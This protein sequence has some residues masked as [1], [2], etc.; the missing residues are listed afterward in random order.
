MKNP[1][2][3]LIVLISI[4]SCSS[5]KEK[6]AHIF[7]S[8]DSTWQVGTGYCSSY[9]ARCR[10]V[11]GKIEGNVTLVSH[12]SNKIYSEETYMGG[13]KTGKY[14]RYLEPGVVL[15]ETQLLENEGKFKISS[16]TKGELSYILLFEKEIFY[17]QSY[18]DYE[19]ILRSG[20][21]IRRFNYDKSNVL[22]QEEIYTP[23]SSYRDGVRIYYN[24]DGSISGKIDLKDR[25][26]N[27]EG[28]W[29]AK[30]GNGS[31][32]ERRTYL[33]GILNGTCIT[34][35]PN[36]KIKLECNYEDG[37]LKGIYREYYETG[38]PKKVCNY[39]IINYKLYKNSEIRGLNIVYFQNGDSVYEKDDLAKRWEEAQKEQREQEIEEQSYSSD[40]Q[41][42]PECFGHYSAGFCTQCG[43]ASS[44]R[45]NQSYSKLAD[46]EF[47]GGTGLI[48]TGGTHSFKKRCTSCNG[49]GKQAY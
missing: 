42:C 2:Y 12:Y 36:E 29:I 41:K 39:E 24:K 33:N 20:E 25:N 21:E 4:I 14:K 10:I 34:Y 1:L 35:Y 47:C 49:K 6:A 15:F 26:P 48:E 30:Y 27:F 5:N 11:N 46:C 37:R 31:I 22:S 43:R 9:Q 32:K 13:A 28:E 7:A 19:D 3:C 38:K 23:E 17:S 44:E 18:K 8:R 45:K 40:G 16:Y